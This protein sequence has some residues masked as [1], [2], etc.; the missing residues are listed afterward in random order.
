VQRFKQVGKKAPA[1]CMRSGL[2]FRG[3]AHRWCPTC[4]CLFRAGKM[5]AGASKHCG[6]V[7]RQFIARDKWT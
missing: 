7:H 2:A 6:I 4:R 5:S 3:I 1:L